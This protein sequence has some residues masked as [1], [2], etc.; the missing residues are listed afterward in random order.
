MLPETWQPFEAS[1][2]SAQ[3]LQSWCTVSK[4]AA[5]SEQT[6]GCLVAWNSVAT[7]N[8]SS[9]SEMDGFPFS[10]VACAVCRR[11]RR[12][13][14]PSLWGQMASVATAHKADAA[15]EGSWCVRSCIFWWYY[16][17]AALFFWAVPWCNVTCAVTAIERGTRRWKPRCWSRLAKG[18]TLAAVIVFRRELTKPGS[19]TRANR[20]G[21]ASALL[22]LAEHCTEITGVGIGPGMS[23]WVAKQINSCQKSSAMLRS[24]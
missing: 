7:S 15:V 13:L 24:M 22:A 17:L 2:W 23:G 6:G 19:S 18:G 12:K 10:A 4:H 16:N 8:F 1:I 11:G 3:L 21:P 14:R 20:S 9:T 5:M